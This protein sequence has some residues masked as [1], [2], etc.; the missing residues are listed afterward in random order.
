MTVEDI[1][2]T[3][4]GAQYNCEQVVGYSTVYRIFFALV[5]FFVLMAL[6]TIRVQN[7][8]EFRAKFHNG[9]AIGQMCVLR[10][11]YIVRGRHE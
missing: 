6:F 10:Y 9:Y 7:S 8:R 1:G 11:R 5:C 4:S 2:V 3:I